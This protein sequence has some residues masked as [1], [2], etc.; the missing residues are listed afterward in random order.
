MLGKYLGG[1]AKVAQPAANEQGMVG[2]GIAG[3]GANDNLVE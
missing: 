3:A 1:E 2:N